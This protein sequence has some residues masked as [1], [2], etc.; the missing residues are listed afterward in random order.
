MILVRGTKCEEIPAS[1]NAA[2]LCLMKLRKDK[3]QVDIERL[4]NKLDGMGKK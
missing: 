2:R 1:Y 3:A 4:Q